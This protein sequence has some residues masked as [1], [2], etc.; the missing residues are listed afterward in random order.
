MT[1]IQKLDRA[2]SELNIMFY[3]GYYQGNGE[4]Y[5]IYEG[6]VESPE[7]SADNEAQMFLKKSLTVF[8]SISTIIILSLFEEKKTFKVAQKRRFH[9]RRRL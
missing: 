9:S 8:S 1:L 2:L 7:M 4:D 3:P 5:G 6:I